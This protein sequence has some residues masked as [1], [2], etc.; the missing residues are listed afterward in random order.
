MYASTSRTS[1]S[2]VSR[3]PGDFV[4]LE[5]RIHHEPVSGIDQPILKQRVRNSLDDPAVDLAD[6][7]RRIHGPAAVMH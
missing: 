5:I 1:I 6:G 2:G 4:R 3:D 7:Q